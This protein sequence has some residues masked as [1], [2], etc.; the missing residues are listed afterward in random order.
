VPYRHHVSDVTPANALDPQVMLATTMHS[1]PGVYALLLGS[2]VSTGAGIP[3]GW[4][5]VRDLVRRAAAANA[6]GDADAAQIA[7]DDPESW[8]AEH[9]DGQPLG[10]SNLLGGLAPAA[11]SR[12]ALLAGFFEPSEDDL[13]AG[14]KVP[15]PAHRAISDLVKRGSVKVIVTTNFDRLTER[16]LEDAGVSPQVISSTG[17]L[18]GMAPLQHAAATVIKLHGDYADLLQRNTVDELT[19]YPAE[20]DALLDRV[21]AEYGLLISGWSAAWD[22][23]LV[24]ALERLPVRR[25]PL[26]WDSR[27]AKGEAAGR[28][29][30]QQSGTVVQTADADELFTGLSTR[31]DALDRLAEPPLTTALA[32]QR[33]KRYLPDE[34]RRIDFYDLVMGQVDKSAHAVRDLP[35]YLDGDFASKAND[36][37][38]HCESVADPLIRLVQVGIQHDTDARFA[39]LWIDGLRRLMRAAPHV[40]GRCQDSVA[41]LR[42]YPALLYLRAACTSSLLFERDDLMLSLLT[43]PTLRE[44]FGSNT[45]V[46]AAHALADYYVLEPDLVNA[47]PRYNNNWTFP[48][49]HHLRIALRH[50]FADLLPGETEYIQAQD[51]TEFCVAL[52]QFQTSSPQYTVAMPGEFVSR[53]RWSDGMP[54]AEGRF[55]QRVERAGADWP[56]FRFLDGAEK[57][58][59]V[60]LSFRAYLQEMRR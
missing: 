9:G 46:T 47:L 52:V 17:A 38:A 28:L 44:Q 49:S 12:Q 55:R 18:A 32:I 37:V 21:L 20:W 34:R 16:A 45:E 30:A 43:R 56:W 2:G 6:P 59:D 41:A 11:A 13:D 14:L 42:R 27:S 60:L 26:F 8:W 40:D 24:A 54:A 5:V 53:G 1:Q 48:P 39:D 57:V 19:T 4:G 23:A 25:Y 58:D 50:L 31:L 7:Y 22:H 10:Y 51:D 3:T 33:L 36:L 29:V 35:Q 15:S